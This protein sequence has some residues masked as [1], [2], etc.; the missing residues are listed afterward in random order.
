MTELSPGDHCKENPSPP[1]L[2]THDDVSV[3]TVQTG[4]KTKR[5]A[6]EQKEK[7]VRIDF[8]ASTDRD[9]VRQIHTCILHKWQTEDHTKIITNGNKRLPNIDMCTWNNGDHAKAFLTHSKVAKNTGK[10]KFTIVHHLITMLTMAMLPDAVCKIMT[11][12]QVK[13]SQ[14]HWN[15][16]DVNV[17]KLGYVIGL[18]PVHYS[19]EE[20]QKKVGQLF[21]QSAPS[22]RCLRFEWCL[23]PHAL[24]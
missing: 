14:H 9:T 23:R 22:K 1:E 6:K 19:T 12:H 17:T 11:K 7:M 5:K 10:C 15:K 18:H 4:T 16:E 20:A 21:Q 24:A 13:L 8:F 2:S 3:A